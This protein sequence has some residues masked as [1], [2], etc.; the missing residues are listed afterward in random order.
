M[1]KQNSIYWNKKKIS[2][3]SMQIVAKQLYVKS[4]RLLEEK[5]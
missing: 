1:I 3:L 4:L 5:S 2:L